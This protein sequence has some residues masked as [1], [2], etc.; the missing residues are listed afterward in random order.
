MYA[1]RHPSLLQQ[2]LDVSITEGPELVDEADPRKELRV[3]GHTLF[4]SGH[5]DE[6]HAHAT[7]IEDGAQLLQTVHRQTVGFINDDQ[8]RRVRDCFEPCLVLVEG[9]VVR[10]LER[11]GVVGPVISILTMLDT[12]SLIPSAQNI[13]RCALFCASCS[14]RNAAEK[15]PSGP[16]VVLYP[17]RCVDDFRCEEDRVDRLGIRS[18][19]IP[20]VKWNDFLD[21]TVVDSR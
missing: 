16:D 18:L 10:R 6:H 12:P 19:R 13:E 17:R 9:V 3:A 11:K 1:G 14:F 5:A 15:G 8:S 21:A 20:A 2:G 4:D 7:S